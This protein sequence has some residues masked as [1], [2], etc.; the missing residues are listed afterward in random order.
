MFRGTG[1]GGGGDNSKKRR[2]GIARAVAN[3][4]SAILKEA[5][6]SAEWRSTF[7]G[8]GGVSSG[9]VAEL[10]G[11]PCAMPHG[12]RVAAAEYHAGGS[13]RAP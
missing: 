8:L 12:I 9:A 10:H 2:R 11:A 4:K 13:F 6:S 1:G 3:P 7:S 5:S